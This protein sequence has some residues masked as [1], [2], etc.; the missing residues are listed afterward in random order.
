MGWMS[1]L[2]KR[3]RGAQLVEF[4]LLAPLLI[5]LVLGIV[6]FGF[7]FSQFNELRHGVREGARYAAVSQPDLTGDGSVTQADVMKAVCDSVDLPG[8]SLSVSLA[9]TTG[10]GNR[11]DYSTLTVVATVSSL[12]GAPII[13]SFIPS[14]LT[15]DAQFRLEQ[16][17]K[18]STFSNQQCP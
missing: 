11:L 9:N 3:D 2:R 4:A 5:L 14:T 1:K 13:S 15:N 6:E 10:S 7:K 12:T 8:V 18:W 17:A 16:D